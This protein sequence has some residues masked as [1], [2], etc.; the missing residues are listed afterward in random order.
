[1]RS[2]WPALVVL[3]AC[4]TG[5]A[6][7]DA[8]SVTPIPE[9]PPT[10][11]ADARPFLDNL[12][13]DTR[14]VVHAKAELLRSA[15]LGDAGRC[16]ATFRGPDAE[17]WLAATESAEVRL[18]VRGASLPPDA[19][20]CAQALLESGLGLVRTQRMAPKVSEQ[21]RMAR[22]ETPRFPQ[23]VGGP[24]PLGFDGGSP[25]TVAF[26]AGP[27]TSPFRALLTSS[28]QASVLTLHLAGSSEASAVADRAK[29]WLGPLA[30]SV[31]VTADTV[32]ILSGPLD[33]DVARGIRKR[34]DV[35]DVPSRSME[36]TLEQDDHVVIE[37]REGDVARGDIVVFPYPPQPDQH[38]MQRVVAVGGDTV[39]FEGLTP[40]VNGKRLETCPVGRLERDTDRGKKSY[41]VELERNGAA[42]YL[43]QREVANDGS[44][45]PDC[46]GAC[47]SK[48]P[49]RVPQGHVFVLG[50]GRDYSHDSR[51]FPGTATVSATS[52]VGRPILVLVGEGPSGIRFD[53]IGFP[54]GAKP[55]VPRSLAPGYEACS[56]KAK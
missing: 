38:F 34:I 55:A 54:I 44:E 7:P 46:S 22:A 1:M 12:P 51:S 31:S 27:S 4:S 20:A 45:G 2:G 26:D 10:P 33:E 17:V 3:L 16:A 19:G 43:I 18:E 5:R 47:S 15:E 8:T 28:E 52:I 36:P 39:A 9:P 48:K 11:P 25:L 40:V 53:R 13:P 24:K 14:L 6:K 42:S 21:P 50:D 35:F 41:A 23:G 29:R 32:R 30:S 49:L 56:R 37:K